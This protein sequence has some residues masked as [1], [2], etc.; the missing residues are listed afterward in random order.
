MYRLNWIISFLLASFCLLL[1]AQQATPHCDV[2]SLGNMWIITLD[3]SGS[4]MYE[5]TVTGEKIYWPTTRI[6]DDVMNKLS[7]S[8]GILDQIDYSRDRITFI[9]TGYATKPEESHGIGFCAAAPLD[10][11]F[12]HIIKPIQNFKTNKKDGVEAVLS[13]LLSRRDYKYQ[14]SFVSQI[15]VLSLHRLVKLICENNLGLTFDKINIV[16]ITDDADVN[17]QWRNDYY[18]IKRDRKKVQQLNE[19]H[20]KYVFSSFTQKGA[21]ILNE[22]EEFTDLSSKNHIY[23][24]EYVTRQQLTN[25][26]LCKEDSIISITPL[27][28][29]SIDLRLNR[30]EIASDSICFVYIDTITINSTGYP[31]CRYM[32]DTLHINQP[33]DMGTVQNDIVIRGKVQVQYWDS[34]YGAHYKS[35]D[36]VQYNKDYTSSIHSIANATTIIITTLV[37]ALLIY[38]LFILPN[39]LVM[40]VYS[41]D[42]NKVHIRRGYGWQWENLT[43]LAYYSHSACLFAKHNCFK[44]ICDPAMSYDSLNGIIIDSPAPLIITK[45][46]L[47]AST[48]N[49]IKANAENSCEMFPDIV[50]KMYENTLAGYFSKLQNSRFKWIRR[51]LHPFINGLLFSISP[52]YY[53]WGNAMQGLIS[54]PILDGKN[55][56][57]E[58]NDRNERCS[59]DDK[60]LN[61]YYNGDYPIADVLI[62]TQ[63]INSNVMWDVYRLCNRKI[64]GY[65]ISSAKHLIHYIQKDSDVSQLGN[66]RK[67]LEKAIRHELKVNKIA[68][69]DSTS[70]DH[71]D[72]W[73]HFD[74]QKATCMAYVCLVECTL[75]EKCQVLYSPFTDTDIEEKNVVIAASAVSRHIWTSLLPFTSKKKRPNGNI[76]TYES[77][78]IVREGPASQTKLSLKSHEI[79]FN[80]ICI[81]PQKTK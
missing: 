56:L 74:V 3:K 55:M 36:F 58:F 70:Y 31:V 9:E 68:Y 51:K 7:H 39:R 30:K 65:G 41:P 49:N 80:N 75:D 69:I 46:A 15:R 61:K 33:Y 47:S 73:M 19:L 21:G 12:I 60:S 4:M 59:I 27:D 8:G 16:T 28:G 2:D 37:L 17:D 1:S 10:S 48:R 11:S 79:K 6:K 14:E 25:E 42:G 54:T 77:A 18:T 76:A 32:N 20:S 26:I 29:E 50:V 44:R 67:Q 72:K 13:N 35:Y 63:N 23:M 24:Y 38:I 78:D 66:I 62:S 45:N 22:K 34:I 53:Y 43:P 81:K 5:K 52:H 64:N 71:H 57:I 40:K